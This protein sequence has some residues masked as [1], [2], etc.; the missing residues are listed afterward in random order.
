[1][2]TENRVG[3][4]YGSISSRIPSDLEVNARVLQTILLELVAGS[5]ANA[6]FKTTED[7][8]GDVAKCCV[9]VSRKSPSSSSFL[10]TTVDRFKGLMMMMMCMTMT[11]HC[12]SFMTCYHSPSSS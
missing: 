9:H 4:Y 5:E 10:E 12:R 3:T 2:Q 6:L 7:A 11:I 1:M 8:V